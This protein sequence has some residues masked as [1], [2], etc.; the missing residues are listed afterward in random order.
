MIK[1]AIQSYSFVKSKSDR[2][3]LSMMLLD[4][5]IQMSSNGLRGSDLMSMFYSVEGRTLLHRKEILKFALNLPIKFKINTKD[6]NKH[7]VTKHIL[8]KLFLKHFPK[9]LVLTKQGFSGFPNEIINFM[10]PVKKFVINNH[11]NF[12]NFEK[13]LKFDR[14][15]NWKILNTEMYLKRIGYKYL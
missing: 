3:K 6:K 5:S 13:S 4:S 12:F 14:A 15:M 2:S 7:M 10:H 9:E 11:I 8:K 1:N